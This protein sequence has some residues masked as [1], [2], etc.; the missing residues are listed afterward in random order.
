MQDSICGLCARRIK[1]AK[2][3]YSQELTAFDADPVSNGVFVL[4]E[5]TAFD[6][7]THPL[8]EMI[9]GPRYR[10]HVESCPKMEKTK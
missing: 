1:L 8:R 5:H 10:Q 6:V 9:G 3:N 4:L 7:S 2:L